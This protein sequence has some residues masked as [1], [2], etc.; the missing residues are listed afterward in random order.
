MRDHLSRLVGLEGFEVRRVAEVGHR[1][2]LTSSRSRGPAAAPGAGA[3]RSTS[4]SA[5]R[6]GCATR[7]S[8]AGSPIWCGASAATAVS[9][10]GRRSRTP[11]PTCRAPA[12]DAA[13]PPAAVR[14]GAPRGRPCRGGA[15]RAH[16]PRAIQRASERAL[17]T[18]SRR[19]ARRR[20]RGGSRST[21]P[22]TAAAGTSLRSSPTSTASA[23]GLLD[24]RSRRRLRYLRSLPGRAKVR[25][26]CMTASPTDRAS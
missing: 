15:R 7:R 10:V 5:R 16:D 22:S 21:R 18:S 19:A 25:T 11:S 24:G 6:C 4:R 9:S 1:L 14:P 13:L 3:R 8:P 12:C 2:D 17:R 20:R 26:L 23:Y